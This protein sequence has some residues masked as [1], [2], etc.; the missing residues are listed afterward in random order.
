MADCTP[1]AP[2]AKAC[3][4]PHLLEELDTTLTKLF[5]R[6]IEACD[7]SSSLERIETIRE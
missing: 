6:A 3:I 4:P 7:A 5:E 1:P 2:A